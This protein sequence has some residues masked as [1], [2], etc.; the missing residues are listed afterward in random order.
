[1]CEIVTNSIPP[2]LRD[3][4]IKLK[5]IS[6]IERGFKINMGSMTFTDSKSWSGALNRSLN[7]E[8]RKGMMV[9]LDQI[10]TQAIAAIS[11]Y[12]GTEFMKII[13]NYLAGAKLGIQNL[14][15]TYQE[16]PDSVAKID[17]C[18]KNIELQL[19]HNSSLLEGHNSFIVE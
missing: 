12:N 4:L 16:D 10:V 6:N 3:L 14:L 1:M 17:V 15:V 2:T 9:H 7:G 13:V 11:E 8:G 5:V 19:S 18:I